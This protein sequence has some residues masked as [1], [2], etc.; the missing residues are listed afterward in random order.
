MA[1]EIVLRDGNR[2]KIGHEKYE[3]IEKILFDKEERPEFFKIKNWGLFKLDQIIY[4]QK[5]DDGRFLPEGY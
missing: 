4:I 1:Y 2:I 3:I 5:E